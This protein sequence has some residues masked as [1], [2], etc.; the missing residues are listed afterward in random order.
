VPVYKS[1]YK[2]KSARTA[3]QSFVE[4]IQ[5][6]L[7][8]QQY[9]TGICLDLTRAYDVVNHSILLD[10][11][12]CYGIRGTGKAW[13]ESYL[14]NRSQFVEITHTDYRKSTQNSY[15]SKLRKLHFGILQGSI[16]GPVLFLLYI[17]DLTTFK[18]RCKN[19]PL[20]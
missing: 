19:G 1:K 11:L 20:C 5:E 16:L 4:H 14:S 10:K 6:A 3:V 9:V 13:F 17:N 2:Y 12:E 15:S 8:K 7:A 18:K